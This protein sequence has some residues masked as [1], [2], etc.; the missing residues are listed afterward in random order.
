M[1]GLLLALLLT[2]EPPPAL[3]VVF[4]APP[5]VELWVSEDWSLTALEGARELPGAR[6]AIATRSNM[7]RPELALMLKKRPA[8]LRIDPRLLQAHVEQLRKLPGVTLVVKAGEGTAKEQQATA[9]RLSSVG[10]QGVRLL[11]GR[12]DASSLAFV[13]S[14]RSG[15]LELDLRGRVPDQEELARLQGLTR[16]RRVVRISAAQPP[17]LV[18]GL[19]LLKPSR[20]VVESDDDRLPLPMLEALEQLAAS[21]G[22]ELRVV[23]DEKA[24][25]EDLRRLSSLPNL[26]LELHLE[27]QKEVPR[28][29]QE[30]LR[31]L[32]PKA[33]QGG[34][35]H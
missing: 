12:L 25:L 19:G 29:V 6:L 22:P 20:L 33:L 3:D 10:P 35:E 21:G 13:E 7:L 26:S 8:L 15:E 28:R 16:L 23:I 18:A 2:G 34:S 11:V 4:A 31:S 24:G 1:K 17:A 14:F 30:L 5:K 32:S 27:G 9:A